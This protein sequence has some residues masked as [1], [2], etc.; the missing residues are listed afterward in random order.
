MSSI[1]CE[2]ACSTKSGVESQVDICNKSRGRKERAQVEKKR[3]EDKEKE[4][5]KKSVLAT[6]AIV[7]A[8]V[9]LKRN[10]RLW[11]NSIF[12]V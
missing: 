4:K 10:V 12:S 1:S 7:A 2:R 3:E 6:A 11:N 8:R 5:K 9:S